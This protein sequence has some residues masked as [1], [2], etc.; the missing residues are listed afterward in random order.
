M[1]DFQLIPALNSEL[2]GLSPDVGKNLTPCLYN[3]V[4]IKQPVQRTRHNL[5]SSPD[6]GTTFSKD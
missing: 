4:K 1:T 3:H 6:S 2:S 5:D